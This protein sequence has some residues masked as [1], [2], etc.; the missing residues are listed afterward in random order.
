LELEKIGG[1]RVG[2]AVTTLQMAY[3]NAPLLKSITHQTPFGDATM[4]A[5]SS[6]PNA[7]TIEPSCLVLPT[8]LPLTSELEQEARRASVAELERQTEQL[9]RERQLA[10]ALMESHHDEERKEV[11]EAQG[12]WVK[13]IAG[14]RKGKSKVPDPAEQE[15]KTKGF[16]RPPNAFELY[17]AIDKKDIG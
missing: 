17:A 9:E 14:K 13:L 2:V 15:G 10:E 8:A 1:S 16:D 12:S 11:V 5:P 4:P 3:N 7:H 6:A